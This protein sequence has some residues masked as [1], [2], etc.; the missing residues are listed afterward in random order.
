MSGA[1]LLDNSIGGR[2]SNLAGEVDELINWAKALPDDISIV[3]SPY[4]DR[5]IF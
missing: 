3:S 4:K 2:S 1:K 5:S